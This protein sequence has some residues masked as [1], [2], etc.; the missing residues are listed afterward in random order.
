MPS[1]EQ[2]GVEA[3]ASCLDYRRV[4][5]RFAVLMTPPAGAALVNVTVP[6][7]DAKFQRCSGKCLV[8]RGIVSVFS[9][10]KYA[11]VRILLG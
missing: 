5:V 7:L 9:W 6:V 11:T 1:L 4:I 8:D 3:R 2:S 10:R